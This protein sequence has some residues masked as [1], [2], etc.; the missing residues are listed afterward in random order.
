MPIIPDYAAGEDASSLARICRYNVFG[1]AA[2]NKKIFVNLI[3]S[4][5][6]YWSAAI[7]LYR[8]SLFL[9]SL[10][11]P[12]EGLL[13]TGW[14]LYLLAF[15]VIVLGTLSLL[16]ARAWSRGDAAGSGWR[17]AFA[18]NSILFRYW[19][20]LLLFILAAGAAFWLAVRIP[21]P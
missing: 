20:V 21:A 7:L 2:M 13:F 18:R 6:L 4:I 5:F 9:S 17:E 10:K 12:G 11:A 19:P 1:G 8:D 15:S 14:S 3:L 16:A